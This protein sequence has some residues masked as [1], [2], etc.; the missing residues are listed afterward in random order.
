MGREFEYDESGATSYYF[1]LSFLSLYLV[2][3]TIIKLCGLCGGS[4]DDDE[5]EQLAG[6]AKAVRK[7]K[8]EKAKGGWLSC[9]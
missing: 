8:T 4:E 7:K 6:A 2:P 3:A 1:V 9:G 5:V